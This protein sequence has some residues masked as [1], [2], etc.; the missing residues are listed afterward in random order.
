MNKKKVNIVLNDFP[1]PSETFLLNFILGL[2]ENY[3]ITLLVFSNRH[4]NRFKGTELFRQTK[5]RLFP[6]L[7]SLH[8]AFT[9][10]KNVWS[11]FYDC[12]RYRRKDW[13]KSVKPLIDLEF[14]TSNQ[15]DLIY[16]SYSVL[17]VDF[18]NVLN[19][20]KNR[21]IRMMVSCRGTS[22]NVKPL[23]MPERKKV[24]VD[25]LEKMDLVHCVSQAMVMRLSTYGYRSNNVFVNYPSV[26]TEYFQKDVN[27]REQSG[28][29]HII[30]LSTGRLHYIKGYIHALE[31]IKKL[32]E[33][34]FNVEYRIVGS[35]PEWEFLSF[36]VED[37]DLGNCVRF[38]QTL[39]PIEVKQQLNNADIFLLSSYAEGVSNAVLEAM[40]MEL[41]VISTN[42]GGMREVISHEK[43][44]LLIK[45]YD[46]DAI[47]NAIRMLISSP[48]LAC[49]I[50]KA[51]R[52]AIVSRYNIGLQRIVFRSEIDA[53]IHE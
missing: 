49:E 51:A 52:E 24:L 4:L 53:L 29:D 19:E 17:A 22:E 12:L 13:Y 50:G 10:L 36:Y 42:V 16:F 28:H 45:P 18:N 21:N 38:L 41:P 31:G 23:I 39:S 34:G 8:L 27:N 26:D 2:N 3:Q 46:S 20:L 33:E 37:N 48:S 11:I 30:I 43:D 9:F 14:L 5:Y 32:I 40:A 6:K 7:F 25:V 1:S 44:G 15:P 35:G 47:Y